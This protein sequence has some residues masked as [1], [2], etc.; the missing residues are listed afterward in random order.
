[1][2]PLTRKMQITLVAA[3]V[4]MITVLHY[5]T[6][7]HQT[8]YH[9]F[10]RELYFFPLIM[11]GTWFGV[12]GALGTSLTI[13]LLYLPHI[14][15]HWQGNSPEDFGNVIEIILFNAVAAVLG[16][17]SDQKKAEQERLQKY[18]NL[19][20][21]GQSISCIGHDM[22]A[23][24]IA[25]GGFARQIRNKVPQNDP[26]LCKLDVIIREALRLE[27]MVKDMQEFAKPLE[28]ELQG[29]DLNL[30]IEKSQPIFEEI[31]QQAQVKLAT[32]LS[33]LLPVDQKFDPIR[34]EQVLINLVTNAIQASPAGETVQVLTELEKDRVVLS[35]K[36]H[37]S[38]FPQD[39]IDFLCKPFFTTKKGGTGLGLSIVHKIVKAHQCYLEIQNNP[40][41]G[42]TFKIR[43]P[44]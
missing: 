14:M 35:V 42:S 7:Q 31:A 19:A 30:L 38:G 10:Y 3:L 33:L 5:T 15:M 20:S 25:I 29:G 4:I 11:A 1:M 44:P 43:L 22:K 24:L 36:D 2:E 18:E 34:M 41:G 17:V 39:K 40:E 8:Y 32:C 26:C 12:R 21:I 37:G 28:L 23:P 6:A 16:I 9:I 13:S 27:M